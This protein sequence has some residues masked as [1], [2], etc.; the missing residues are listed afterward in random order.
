MQ[1]PPYIPYLYIRI[2][3]YTRTYILYI[4]AE[5]ATWIGPR[6]QVETPPESIIHMVMIIYIIII[7][8]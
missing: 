6:T 3:V 8:R 5:H 1:G 7:Q 2:Y 4:Y